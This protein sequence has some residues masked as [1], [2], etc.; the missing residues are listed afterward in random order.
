MR[1]YY[2]GEKTDADIMS[3]DSRQVLP[4]PTTDPGLDNRAPI[5]QPDPEPVRKKIKKPTKVTV[6]RRKK[7]RL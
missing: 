6:H 5:G 1:V 7:V 4:V 3:P 2:R